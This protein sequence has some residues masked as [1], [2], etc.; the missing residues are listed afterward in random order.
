M[1]ANRIFTVAGEALGIALGNVIN[2]TGV[3]CIIIGG[4]IANSWKLLR[5]P[6]MQTLEKNVFKAIFPGVK[7]YKAA[8]GV[9]A[10]FVGAARL[11]ASS[12]HAL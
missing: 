10:G 12:V 11:A 3:T 9:K 4:G 5:K 1:L 7:V 8:L 6:V 2:L